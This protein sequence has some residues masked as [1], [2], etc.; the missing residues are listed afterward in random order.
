MPD[1]THEYLFDVKLFASIRVTAA[2]E[3]QARAK[4]IAAIDCNTANFGAW[5]DGN[6]ITCEVSLDNPD[7]D[8]LIEID[9]EAV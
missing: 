1:V 4:L 9:G 2:T 7:E 6:P 3:A 8:T 5:P